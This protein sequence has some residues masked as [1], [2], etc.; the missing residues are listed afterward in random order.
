M[1]LLHAS[2]INADSL[3]DLA[4]ILRRN[5]LRA[6]TLKRVLKDPAYAMPDGAADKDGDEWLSRWSEVL[7][8]ELPWNSFPEPP[9]DIAA[10][11]KRLDT[12]P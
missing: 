5:H 1:F 8:K 12:E 10:A 7:H 9:A 4:S 11:D 3:D 2:R 6:T